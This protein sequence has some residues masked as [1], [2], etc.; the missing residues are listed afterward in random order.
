MTRKKI[1]EEGAP[2][3][4]FAERLRSIRIAR[5]LTVKEL[6]RRTGIAVRSIERY[7]SGIRRPR[8]AL[9]ALCLELDVDPH[10]LLTGE[11]RLG[12]FGEVLAKLEGL[13]LAI[14]Q[15]GV[16]TDRELEVLR[17]EVLGL[18][19][20]VSSLADWFE[21]LEDRFKAEGLGPNAADGK[22]RRK[23]IADR[24]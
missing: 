11:Y 8:T 2:H 24:G 15:S 12:E 10:W 20:D 13:E 21:S 19:A 5:G 7:E 18:R 9:P 3:A 22:K 17:G 1:S 16:I 6:A 4:A 14:R 23:R